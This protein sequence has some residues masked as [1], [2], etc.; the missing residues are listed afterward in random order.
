[1]SPESLANVDAITIHRYVSGNYDAIDNFQAPW[2]QAEQADALAGRDLDLM[3]TEWNISATQNGVYRWSTATEA[4]RAGL[5]TGLKH[6]GAVAAMFH[7]MVVNHVDIAAYWA[8]QQQN[9]VSFALREGTT[10]DLRAGGH[11]FAYLSDN[12]QG[13][14]AVELARPSRNF[15]LHAFAG[16]EGQ[17]IVINSRLDATQAIDLDME[18]LTGA[19]SGGWVHVMTAAAGQDPRDPNVKTVIEQIPLAEVLVNGRLNLTLDPWEVAVL[20]L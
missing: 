12:V 9:D 20:S 19:V 4:Q 14:Q 8:V 10:T 11:M 7:E 6:A 1:M 13:M 16:A 5:D 2:L 3:V 15:D 17:F 18:Q